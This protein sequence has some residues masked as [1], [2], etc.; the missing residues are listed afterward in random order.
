[1]LDS[2]KKQKLKLVTV[3]SC[4]GGLIASTITSIPGS[5]EVY[6]RG[7][8]TYSNEAK[9]ELV[10]VSAELIK[11]HGAVS[12]EVAIAM[13]EGALKVT[14]AD[15]AVSATGIAGPVTS[16]H[17]P[18]GRVYIAVAMRG[19]KAKVTENHITGTRIQIQAETVSR[20]I[21]LINSVTK[22]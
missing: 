14:T 5:S 22:N 8:I 4:T 16:E 20:A 6:D 1:M 3:E 11:A 10:G 7:F 18:V 15:I 17:K 12:R 21:D 2:L 9:T 13:A 19:K